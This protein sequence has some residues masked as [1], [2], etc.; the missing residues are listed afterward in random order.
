[1][2]A[3]GRTKPGKIVT[4]AKAGGSYHN[5]GLAIDFCLM[6]KGGK[7]VSWDRN[8]DTDAD[9]KKDWDEVVAAFKHFGWEWGGDWSNFKDYP[10]FQKTLGFSTADL[11]KKHNNKELDTEGF[12]KI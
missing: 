2:Y 3:K 9:N 6:L 5:Y 8:K 12:V 11:L 1:M 4:H 10:H 7:E